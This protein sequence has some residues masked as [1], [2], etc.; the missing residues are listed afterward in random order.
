MD[1]INN[2]PCIERIHREKI[3]LKQPFEFMSSKFADMLGTVVLL[4]GTDLDCARYNI[5]AAMPWLTLTGKNKNLTLKFADNKIALNKDP[6]DVVEKLINHFDISHDPYVS[7]GSVPVNAGLFG[8][9]G[10]DL[11][12][13]IEKLPKTCIDQGLP[14][15]VLFAPSI[16]LIND[17]KTDNTFLCIPVISYNDHGSD[18]NCDIQPH[19]EYK[20]SFKFNQLHE[21][22]LPGI[23]YKN[24]KESSI[25]RLEKIRSFFLNTIND[26]SFSTISQ[27]SDLSSTSSKKFS[28]S[29]SGFKSNFTKQEYI[30][31]VKKIIEYIK[32][33]D[34][35]Q[36]NLSQRF[37]A[38]FKGDC[39]SLFLKLFKKNPAPFFA[40]INAEDH[41]IL[42]TSPERFIK[43]DK[44]KIE[45]RPIKGTISREKNPEKDRKNG[46]ELLSSFKDDAE[47]SMIVDLMRNDLGKVAK[48]GSVRV[49]EHKRLESYD[50]VFHL[51][52]IVEAVLEKK[53][54]SV[55]LIRATFPGGSITGCP[56]V[57]TMEIID[58]LEPVNRHVYTGSIGYLSFHDTLDL[59]I[60]I[61]TAIVSN[62]IIGFSVGG[63][64]V[65]DSVPEKEFK[66]TLDKG[67]TFLETLVPLS[68]KLQKK[69]KKAWVNGRIIDEKNALISATCPG[70]QYGAGFFETI[71]VKNGNILFLKE[72]LQRFNSGWQ[73]LFKKN[74]PD[75]NWKDVIDL[76]ISENLLKNKISSV[77]IMGAEK[78]GLLIKGEESMFLAAFAKPYTHRLKITGKPGIELVT[79]P[80][81]RHTHLADYK[82]LNYMYYYLAAMYAKEKK[83]DEA[84]I[85]NSDGTVSETNTCSIMSFCSDKIIIP[86]SSH[87]LPGIALNQAKDKLYKNGFN[88]IEKK[89]NLNDF[90]AS[91]QVILTNSLMGAVP[92]ISLDG[93]KFNK[94]NISNT[95]KICDLINSVF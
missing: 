58:E 65:Y 5:L 22:S 66:E 94:N 41:M 77:K 20:K 48:G 14:D 25:E 16:I 63:G 32:A 9:L 35:Y 90:F 21:A 79:Y 71:K 30:N 40:F 52:S 57:R 64:I 59:S 12:D 70:F 15:I 36:V 55:D 18:L 75:I 78:G 42:S 28:I 8:Y 50:N 54:S 93:K 43:R 7:D 62:G 1:F 38:E 3:D 86:V 31:S 17:R 80:H 82:T 51:V 74:P 60:A 34:I 68:H 92:V 61:R 23:S 95:K 46:K 37:E 91:D 89:I 29:A 47:L 33:G 56:K 76:V 87:V 44:D 84:L 2:L 19:N 27:T 81:S 6:F 13:R 39:Y 45:T 85:L 53:K 24:S 26:K 49:K 4:S 83:A 72:H 11:K 73:N 88:I 10:Y 67:K 69:E